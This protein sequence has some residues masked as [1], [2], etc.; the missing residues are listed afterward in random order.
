MYF[1]IIKTIKNALFLSGEM[2]NKL[3][4]AGGQTTKF[5]INFFDI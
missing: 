2:L 4:I 1:Y 3:N 5:I